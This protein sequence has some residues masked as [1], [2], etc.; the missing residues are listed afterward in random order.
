MSLTDL[1]S[2]QTLA[3]KALFYGAVA[4][5]LMA[6][7]AAGGY[8]ACNLV[9]APQLAARDV[10]IA[11]LKQDAAQT[12]AAGATAALNDLTAATGTIRQAAAA[13]ASFHSTLGTQIAQLRED[14]KHAPQPLPTDCKPDDFR[15]RRLDAA[16]DGATDSANRPQ[17][18]PR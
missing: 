4:C 3:A 15:V 16:I 10:T 5:G 1:F 17:A 18:A 11:S 9:K 13:Y 14:L 2:P 12:R 6:T 7:G 8:Y